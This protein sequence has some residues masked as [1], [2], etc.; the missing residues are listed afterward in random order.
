[1]VGQKAQLCRG[2]AAICDCRL[3]ELANRSYRSL[4]PS[5]SPIVNVYGV[6]LGAVDPPGIG[7]GASAAEPSVFDTFLFATPLLL[8]R[9]LLAGV[10]DG[11]AAAVVVVP[12]VP[13]FW[14]EAINA[15]PTIAPI[16]HNR[17][18]FI[19][20]VSVRLPQNCWLHKKLL[21]RD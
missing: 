1:L 8:C 10:G 5:N 15:M 11:M 3:C 17:F 9:D 19:A 2:V 12:V 21:R 16:M 4:N 18:L 6:G 13:W 7:E 14:Q 20:L